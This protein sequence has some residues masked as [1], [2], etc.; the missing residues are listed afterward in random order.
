[1]RLSSPPRQLELDLNASPEHDFV[2]LT[3]TSAVTCAFPANVNDDELKE[4]STVI[5]RPTEE[6]TVRI[7]PTSRGC[8]ADMGVFVGHD[9]SLLPFSLSQP[10]EAIHTGRQRK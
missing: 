6:H 2:C 1:M 10:F 3:E 9:V 5:G 7:L 4:G 8:A